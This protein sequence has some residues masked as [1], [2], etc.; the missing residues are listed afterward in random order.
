MRKLISII[1]IIITSSLFAQEVK[2]VTAT[3]SCL[4]VNISAEQAKKIALDN[5]RAEAIK[6]AI[7]TKVTEEIF[8][9]VSEVQTVNNVNEFN[10]VFKK[11]TRSSAYGKIVE[12][13]ATYET[14]LEN[15]YPLYIA[16]IEAKVVEEKGEVDPN[17]KA[18][19][20]LPKTKFIARDDIQNSDKIEFKLWASD[21]CYLYLFNVMSND[22]V[23]LILPNEIIKDNTYKIDKNIQSYQKL[24]NSMRFSVGLPEGKDYAL[25]GLLL[26]AV[27]DKIDFKSDLIEQSGKGMI[28]TYKSALT[29]IMK[30]LVTI[31]QNRRTE[32]FTSF[33]IIRGEIN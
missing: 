10:D 22:S 31:P 1:I 9:S 6:K 13:T 30:W 12:E 4:A 25:E 14:K 17:F 16:N 11:F 21:D 15:G 8:R 32:A 3:G 28:A 29:E 27:K 23:Y 5:A 33:E 2:T 19:I 26:I 18:E 20:I 24:L 7:G